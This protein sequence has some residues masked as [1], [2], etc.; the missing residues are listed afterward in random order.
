MKFRAELPD[1]KHY[2]R[3]AVYPDKDYFLFEDKQSKA[4][5]IKSPVANPFGKDWGLALQHQRQKSD[6]SQYPYRL[7]IKLV[8][9]DPDAI[10]C[11]L[12]R[13]LEKGVYSYSR[14]APLVFVSVPELLDTGICVFLTYSLYSKV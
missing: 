9:P 5:R 14:E 2:K 1:A 11:D 4:I 6:V 8:T 13:R 7:V 10:P 3:L 12:E